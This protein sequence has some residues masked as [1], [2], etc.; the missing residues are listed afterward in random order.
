MRALLLLGV[1]ALGAVALGAVALAAAPVIVDRPIPFSDERQ[2]LSLDYWRAHYG[3][4]PEQARIVP[5][6]IVLHWTAGATLESAWQT[7]APE[8]AA[9][10]RPDLAAKGAVNASAHFL[11]DRDGAIVRLMPEDTMARHCVGLN[12]S[13]IGVE[14]VGGVAGFPLTDAQV[15]ADAALV[16]DLVARFPTITWLLGHHEVGRVEGAPIFRELDPS[17][18]SHKIDPGETFMAAVRAEVADL[19]LRAPP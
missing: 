4:P 11:V 2:R 5:Q 10:G 9:Q 14:N 7:F 19:G 3:A 13:S 16:R 1:V 8:R 6:A 17:Y 12:W 15:R 18:R